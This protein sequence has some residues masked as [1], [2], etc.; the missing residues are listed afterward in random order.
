MSEVSPDNSDINLEIEEMI[1]GS[2]SYS[3][4]NTEVE[5]ASS[6]K[7]KRDEGSKK[8]VRTK[9][10]VEENLEIISS[11][12]EIISAL[13][14]LSEGSSP[15]IKDLKYIDDY[16]HEHE[17]LVYASFCARH[18]NINDNKYW[19]SG[20]VRDA[21]I[22]RDKSGY[23]KLLIVKITIKE[24]EP[25]YLLEIVRKVKS[26]SFFGV[27]FKPP[28]NLSFDILENI[29]DIIAS[30]KGHFL[31]KNILLFPVEKAVRIKHKWGSMKQ[32][33]ENVF[34]VLKEKK[35]FD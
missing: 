33:F 23:R 8:T 25:I 3:Q 20:Y 27:I 17:G 21:G 10:I 18:I 7:L 9:Y 34:D 29:K 19:A 28:Y 31:G 4:E 16:A 15:K 24:V 1:D 32:R 2:N 35:I 6:G 26:D 11:S 22:K 5:D 14:E 13:I 12:E 30:N